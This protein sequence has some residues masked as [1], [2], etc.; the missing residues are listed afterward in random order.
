MKRVFVAVLA[1][2]AAVLSSPATSRA[3]TPTVGAETAIFATGC[4]WCTQSDFDKVVGVV[5]TMPGYI[6]GKTKNPSYRQVVT[7]TT[8]HTE[9]VQVTYDPKIVTY[10][11]LLDVFWNTVDP[12][13]GDGQ[14]CDR[15]NQYRPGVFYTT[16]AQRAA[17]EASKSAL[18]AANRFGQP[19]LVEITKAGEFTP[20]EDEHRDY[21][22]KNS[23]RYT[24]Y[25]HGCGRDQR[26]EALKAKSK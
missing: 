17:A 5:A 1:C 21:Y 11:Q 23:L 12:L 20:A 26:L 15:G 2:L 22:K 24:I 6:G 9:A 7:G 10:T 16:D 8:G 25:R 14:F 4:F 3:Q 13:D 19:I 18:T